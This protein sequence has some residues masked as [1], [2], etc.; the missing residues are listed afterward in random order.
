MFFL[1]ILLL[2]LSVKLRVDLTDALFCLDEVGPYVI[3]PLRAVGVQGTYFEQSSVARICLLSQVG[4]DGGLG[5]GGGRGG[6]GKGHVVV[7]FIDSA[8][9]VLLAFGWRGI[10]AGGRYCACLAVLHQ[11]SR[12]GLVALFI[13]WQHEKLCFVVK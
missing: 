12:W 6:R 7:S 13:A 8:K 10:F 9:N 2:D 3:E 11:T 5:G 4:P 1:L